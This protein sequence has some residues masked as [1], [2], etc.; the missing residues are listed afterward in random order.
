MPAIFVWFENEENWLSL[1]NIAT[2]PEIWDESYE[3]WLN[4]AKQI[5]EEIENKGIEIC[6]I[7]LNADDY[8]C[9]CIENDKEPDVKSCNEYA[10]YLVEK[11]EAQL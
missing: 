6:K 8:L 1:K 2:D 9:W 4:G 3:E 5:Y 11:R 7:V 10:A